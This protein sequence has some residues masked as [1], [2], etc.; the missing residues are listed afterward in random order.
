MASGEDASFGEVMILT[1]TWW[2][3]CSFSTC[4]DSMTGTV[5]DRFRMNK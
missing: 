1:I 2:S 3:D 5:E 4:K